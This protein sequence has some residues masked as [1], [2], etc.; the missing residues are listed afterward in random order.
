MEAALEPKQ[1]MFPAAA[2]GVFL[3]KADAALVWLRLA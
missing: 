3:E 1:Q 2:T